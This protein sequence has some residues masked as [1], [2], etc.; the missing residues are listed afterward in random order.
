[1]KFR[2]LYVLSLL[3]VLISCSNNKIDITT[4]KKYPLTTF[5]VKVG[6]SYFHG[7]I[8]QEDKTIEIGNIERASSITDVEYLLEDEN[9]TIEPDPE[10]L[11]GKWQKEQNLTVTTS[12][13]E[14][15]VYKLLFTKLVSEDSNVLFFDDFLEDGIPNEEKWV[16]CQKQT[17]DW[18]DEMSESYDQA[19]VEDGKLV[20]VAELVDGEYKAGG[21]KTEGK[22]DFTFGKV[23]VRARI[24]KYPNG[25][26]PAIW[27]M[28]KKYI[29]PSWPNC[30]EIDIMEH[31]K[32]E[33]YIHHTIHTNYTYNLKLT[34]EYPNT[35]MVNCNFND[36]IT[37][38]MEWR[39]DKLTFYVD[40][41]ETFSYPNLY[42]EDESEKMQWPFTKD[43]SFYIILNM[44]LGGD[45][46]GSWAGPIDD[47]NLPAIMEVDWVK[48]TSIGDNE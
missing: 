2:L 15:V 25:A 18:N 48:V 34:Q 24:L 1:M 47:V 36:W 40:G 16:L 41:V 20:L 12:K 9:C 26:F 10:T 17:S 22:F 11:I 3:T 33:S 13:N 14:K 32:Q 8:N 29:Y 4:L 35:Q 38:G 7:K 27:L 45:R 39:E 37:Y 19:Y 6:D 42:L 44:G 31:I 30:G 5:A 21:I 46:P 28:P 23:E 43:A